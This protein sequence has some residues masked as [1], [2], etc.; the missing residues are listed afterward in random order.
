MSMCE[1]ALFGNPTVLQQLLKASCH[2]TYRTTCVSSLAYC[3]EGTVSR[4]VD[5][6]WRAG[7]GRG[8]PP[9]GPSS[10][11]WT[12]GYRS[13]PPEGHMR[14]AASAEQPERHHLDRQPQDR[15][16]SKH[17]PQWMSDGGAAGAED[18]AGLTAG[19]RRAKDFEAE[20]QRMKEEWKKEQA[21]L[22][23]TA[24]KP[25]CTGLLV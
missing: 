10:K 20:R 7:K 2:V 19:A 9:I 25:V 18:D 11:E 15:Q 17:N 22:K 14:T 23:G 8:A 3:R 4:S 24:Y 6:D 16:R 5:K 12:D 1:V 21:Q 13:Q